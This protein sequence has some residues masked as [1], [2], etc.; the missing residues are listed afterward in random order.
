MNEA[1]LKRIDEKIEQT[2]NALI[3]DI[4]TL[5]RIPSV[6]GEAEPGAPFGKAPKEVL[7]TVLKMGSEEGF[8]GMDYHVGVVSVAMKEGQPDLGIW[9]HGDVVP[10]GDGWNFEPFDVTEHNGCIIGRGVTDNKGQLA[11]VFHVFKIFKELGI[12]LK[13]NPAI[14]V[15]SNEENGMA[16]MT[17]VSGNS[18]AKGFMNVCTPPAMS[19]VPDSSF[20]V[21]Y[22]GKSAMNIT[23]KSEKSLK[24]CAF[25]AAQDASPGSATAVFSDANLPEK[26]PLCTIENGKVTAFTPPRHGSNPDPDGNMIT[27]IC[28]ALLD[29]NLV[30]EEERPILEFFKRVSLDI[31]GKTLNVETEH[32]VLGKLTVFTKRIDYAKGFPE[33]TLNIRY[34]LGITAEEIA[35]NI[36]EK[37]T[38]AGFTVTDMKSMIL[39]YMQ[40]PESKMV[41][42]LYKV[43]E[44][45]TGEGNKPYTL[46]GGTYAHRLPNAYV[47]GTDCCVPP[48]DFPKG[49]GNEHGV[50]EAASIERLLRAMR[51]YARVLLAL[52]ETEW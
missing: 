52:N 42:L 25:E 19:L 15:G 6:Q 10:A 32:P 46:S 5:V 47:F 43:A 31:H 39:P 38:E 8:Y 9:A 50:D 21:G 23:L 24:S 18:D 4:T 51:I 40:D 13:F 22:G 27:N 20:P 11:A 3:K 34:P 45:I 16:D 30:S 26:L 14:Y 41:Q 17:G 49:R 48:A 2:K 12:K 1:L 28:G 44:S 7:D 33:F 36:S 29:A 35:K 37:A